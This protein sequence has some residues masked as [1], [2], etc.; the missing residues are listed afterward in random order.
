M[1]ATVARRETKR[2][3]QKSRNRLGTEPEF[4]GEGDGTLASSATAEHA[5]ETTERQSGPAAAAQPAGAGGGRDGRGRFVPGNAGGP[6]NPFARQVAQLR[7]ALIQRVTLE[8]INIIADELILQARNGRLEAIKLLFQY[9]IGKPTVAVNPDTLDVEEFQQIYAPRKEIWE[10][11]SENVQCVPPRQCSVLMD[12]GNEAA[13]QAMAEV[14]RGNDPETKAKQDATA[15]AV[16]RQDAQATKDQGRNDEVVPQAPSGNGRNGGAGRREAPAPRSTKGHFTGR[17]DQ[18]GGY[19]GREGGGGV[20]RLRVPTGG[21]KANPPQTRGACPS[22]NGGEQ[23]QG[24]GGGEA[25]GA[26]RSA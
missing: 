26:R 14:L 1:S 7:S 21:G 2:N 15:Q 10:F 25:G 4:D 9:V 22:T 3:G 11:A 13:R 23:R 12:V 5:A 8:D 6:G 20:E 18:A 17:M 19:G 24:R 16:N